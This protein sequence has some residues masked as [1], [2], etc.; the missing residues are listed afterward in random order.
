LGYLFVRNPIPGLSDSAL[1]VFF[2]PFQGLIPFGFST[3]GGARFTRLPWASFFWSFGPFNFCPL[4]NGRDQPA[5]SSATQV[6]SFRLMVSIREWGR[7]IEPIIALIAYEP[8]HFAVASPTKISEL[9]AL[10]FQDYF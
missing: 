3:Q 5:I 2:H 7:Y 4:T 8:I 9:A 1:P 6:P 10:L